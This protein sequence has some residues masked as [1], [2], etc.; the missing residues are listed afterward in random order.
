MRATFI[1]S[2]GLL[3]S[4]LTLSQATLVIPGLYNTGVDNNGAV[5]PTMAQELHYMLSWGDPAPDNA[6]VRP[7]VWHHAAWQAWAT[8]P[9][10]SAWIGPS[11]TTST[12]PD[13]AAGDYSYTLA[14]TFNLSGVDAS[15]VQIA[16]QWATDNTGQIWVNGVYTGY[17]KDLWGFQQLDSFLLEG[18][19]TGNNTIEFRV[20][21]QSG[22]SGLLV[23][24]LT[25][26]DDG[27]WIPPEPALPE[28]STVVAGV[29][30]LIPFG[31]QVYRGRVRNP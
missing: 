23:A 16:G 14:F 27:T 9:A 26:N 7:V 10:G 18:F 5:L 3:L 13:D 29:L 2:I 22:P 30:L 15:K 25:A 6:F 12:Y 20:W 4:G 31:I 1:P 28:P 19:Q 24:G 11:A 8:P 21:N 17:N